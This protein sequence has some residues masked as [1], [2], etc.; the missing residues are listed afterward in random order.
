MLPTVSI[1][2]ASL[3]SEKHIEDTIRSVL[4]QTYRHIEYILVD[5]NSTDDTMSIVNNY[6]AN[7]NKIISEQDNGIY[8]AF[9]KGIIA[10]KGDVILFLNSDDSLYDNK[11]IEK[12]AGIFHRNPEY[13]CVYGNVKIVNVRT[14]FS[15]I[16]GF[17]DL[18]I[19][20]IKNGGVASASGAIFEKRCISRI[21]VQFKIQNC[22]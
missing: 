2:T 3:N 12:I 19:E 14:G 15:H 5:G 4:S 6:R 20:D 9:N 1:I 17:R 7:I 11:V 8:D 10:S 21:H 22:R 13:K 16:K 18:S